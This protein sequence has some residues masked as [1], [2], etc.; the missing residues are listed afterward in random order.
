MVR[1]RREADGSLRWPAIERWFEAFEALPA[2]MATKSDWYTHVQDIPPQ[3]GPG[4]PAGECAAFRR[5]IDGEGGA[6]R[7]PLRPTAASEHPADVLQPGWEAFEQGAPHEAAWRLIANHAPVTRFALRGAGAP[8]AKRFGAALADPY[9]TPAQGEIEGDVDALLRHVAAW[10]L[11]A[12][13]TPDDAALAA[14][15]RAGDEGGREPAAACARYLRDRVGV[16]RDMS[17]P[18]ARQLRA[19]LNWAADQLCAQAGA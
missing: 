3:Y 4:Q 6:W 9:A 11:D 2:Y 18:A 10:L 12:K 7:L 14:D 5:S 16:P 8:G 15:L 19:H 17:Y 1:G 13:P